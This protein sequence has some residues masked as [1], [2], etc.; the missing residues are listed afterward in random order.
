MIMAL[1]HL[2]IRGC[3]LKLYDFRGIEFVILFWHE[4][5]HASTIF[6]RL[7]YPSLHV[8]GH[9]FECFRRF[10]RKF[11]SRNRSWT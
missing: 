11:Q 7:C 10:R 5:L 2:L 4:I 6:S 3:S 1:P 9:A 8:F